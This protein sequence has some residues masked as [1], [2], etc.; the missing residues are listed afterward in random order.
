M[1]MMMMIH[2]EL[3]IPTC[4]YTSCCRFPGLLQRLFGASD[5]NAY[6]PVPTDETPAAGNVQQSNNADVDEDYNANQSSAVTGRSASRRRV[7]RSP[8]SQAPA[9]QT[10]PEERAAEEEGAA[11]THHPGS[12][13]NTNNSSW[14]RTSVADAARNTNS[15]SSASNSVRNTSSTSAVRLQDAVHWTIT[16]SPS[17]SA[18][19]GSRHGM[20]TAVSPGTCRSVNQLDDDGFQTVD[21][22]TV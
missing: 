19:F 5:S 15:N 8:T 2:C 22:F 10:I 16:P 9:L 6:R 1:M 4:V 12:N 14:L 3:S 17:P 18:Q 7:T 13:S 21:L 20:A 11:A